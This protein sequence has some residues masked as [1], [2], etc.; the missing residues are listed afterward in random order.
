MR[1]RSWPISMNTEGQLHPPGAVTKT[2]R[3]MCDNAYN[4]TCHMTM[5]VTKIWAFTAGMIISSTPF[6]L[7]LPSSLP[8]LLRA[9][10]FLIIL[11]TVSKYPIKQDGEGLFGLL[12][13]VQH[14]FALCHML[15]YKSQSTHVPCHSLYFPYS[16][17]AHVLKACFLTSDPIRS[18]GTFKRWG[19][20]EG[21]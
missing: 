6:S 4:T 9:L 7:S 8:V 17:N 3:L 1:L 14:V 21:S 20:V 13:K 15:L 10:V 11:A 12:P 19:L 16:P 18:G 2:D 5:L